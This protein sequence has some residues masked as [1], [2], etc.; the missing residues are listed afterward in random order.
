MV[1][2]QRNRFVLQQMGAW[3]TKE[4]KA[5]RV[6]SFKDLLTEHKRFHRIVFST[7]LQ[8]CPFGG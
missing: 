6:V 8:N 2:Y 3:I 1:I 7:Q 4:G 5:K